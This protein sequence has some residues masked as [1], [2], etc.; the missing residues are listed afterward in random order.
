[1][2]GKKSKLD[3][4]RVAR[5]NKIGFYWG[6]KHG[7]PKTWEK[8]HDELEER[9]HGLGVK[10]KTLSMETELGRW[11]REQRKELKRLKLSKPSPLTIEQAKQLRKL[12]L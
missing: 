5:L 11:V 8:W 2:A 3:A 12:G 1:M 9:V 4:Q 10:P 6:A 7:E